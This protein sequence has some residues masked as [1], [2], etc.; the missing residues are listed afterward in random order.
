M[1]QKNIVRNKYNNNRTERNINMMTSN[2]D[3]LTIKEIFEKMKECSE[4]LRDN[5][6]IILKPPA[7]DK[8]ITA[9]IDKVGSDIIPK[10]YQEWL[11]YCNGAILPMGITIHGICNNG[12]F[13]HIRVPSEYNSVGETSIDAYVFSFHD[14]AFYIYD[15]DGLVKSSFR[16]MLYF[17]LETCEDTVSLYTRETKHDKDGKLMRDDEAEWIIKKYGVNVYEEYCKALKQSRS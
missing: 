15:H 8:Q 16:D 3:E 14:G 6:E 9:Y 5:G 7:T 2:Y 1:S 4:M 10:D 13:G 17:C 11:R 12:I